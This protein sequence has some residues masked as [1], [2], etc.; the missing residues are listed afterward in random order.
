MPEK[1]VLTV[2]EPGPSLV[3]WSVQDFYAN[4]KTPAVKVTYVSNTGTVKVWRYIVSETVTVAQVKAAISFINQGKF[5]VNQ[6][7]SLE[8]W[9]IEQ[10]IA[11]GVLAAGAVTGTVD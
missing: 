11:A 1:L 6:T 7:K 10:G 9:L 4:P 8:K 2:A 3:E 5:M